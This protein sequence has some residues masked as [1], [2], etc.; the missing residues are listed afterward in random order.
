A[1]DWKQRNEAALALG[2]RVVQELWDRYGHH[3]SLYGWYLTHEM[4]D[5]ARASAYYNPMADF[6]HSVSPDK[7]VLVA[8][9]GTPIV[10]KTSLERSHVDIFAYQDAVGSG[11]IP[12]QNTYQ[13][14]KRRVM[15]ETIYPQYKAWHEETDKHLWADLE[16]WE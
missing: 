7:P 1:P 14:D 13:P 16:T 10:D 4:N 3:P 15:L 11:Y 2:R 12:Y 8:P 9:A 6:C 5:L